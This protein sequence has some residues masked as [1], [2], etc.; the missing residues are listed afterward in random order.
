MGRTFKNSEKSHRTGG[1]KICLVKKWVA[2]KR[3]LDNFSFAFGGLQPGLLL[4]LGLALNLL[5]DEGLVDVRDDAAAGDGGLDEGV[6]LLVTS[7]GQLQVAGG[8]S[9]HLQVL[10][11]V[12]GQLQN[13]VGDKQG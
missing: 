1:C 8:D 2:R 7:D 11:S 6:Q 5:A 10:R 9:L 4:L 12:S 3:S 13:L